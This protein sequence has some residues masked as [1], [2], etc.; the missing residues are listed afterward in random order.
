MYIYKGS[1]GLEEFENYSFR[2][3]K[4][5]SWSGSKNNMV[6]VLRGD[7]EQTVTFFLGLKIYFMFN[8]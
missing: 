2:V 7:L 5:D 4:S 3:S 8:Y 6:C 1:M